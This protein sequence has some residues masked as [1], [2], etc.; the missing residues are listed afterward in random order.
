MVGPWFG[1]LRLSGARS[2]PGRSLGDALAGPG[3]IEWGENLRKLPRI[4]ESVLVADSGGGCGGGDNGGEG[5]DGG[6][7]DR[8]GGEDEGAGGGGGGGGMEGAVE[9]GGGLDL[10][11]RF[12]ASGD[13]ENVAAL[14]PDELKNLRIKE[15]KEIVQGRGISTGGGGRR[16][17]GLEMRERGGGSRSGV[18]AMVAGAAGAWWWW[19][20][21]R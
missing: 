12:D 17:L 9:A 19:P 14:W 15:L 21:L 3:W 5:G 13:G 16:G 20:Q 10:V 6:E 7:E 18:A 11:R 1:S 8:G 4:S 2:G